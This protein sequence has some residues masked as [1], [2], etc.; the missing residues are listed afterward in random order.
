MKRFPAFPAVFAAACL[1]S[2]P[3]FALDGLAVF[4]SA[5]SS[6]QQLQKDYQESLLSSRQRRETK[7]PLQDALSQISEDYFRAAQNNGIDQAAL[8]KSVDSFLKNGGK[9]DSLTNPPV[10]FGS[11]DAGEALSGLAGG[12]QSGKSVDY[13]QAF[14]QIAKAELELQIDRSNLSANEKKL[15]K[16]AVAELAG[17]EGALLNASGNH[18]QAKLVKA[19]IPEESAKS[20]ADNV[21]SFISNTDNVAALKNA[22]YDLA[23]SVVSNY[24]GH[25]GAATINAAIEEYR[26]ADGTVKSAAKAALNASIDQYVRD[27]EAN[28]ALKKAIADIENDKTPDSQAVCTALAK[29]AAN[30]LIEE[31]NLSANEKKL[32]KAAVAELAGEEGALLNATGEHIMTKLVKAGVA[33]EQAKSISG[34]IQTFLADT[35]NTAA[36]KAAASESLQELVKQCVDEKGAAT[37]NSAIR[38]YMKADGT[39]GSAAETALNTAIDQ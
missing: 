29:S 22:S 12:I 16:A 24:V 18:I 19:G 8:G 13:K 34:N 35:G 28:A 5:T 36:I 39:V 1:L 30:K 17:E 15:A 26:S 27:P 11:T 25:K 31:S 9:I 32:A 23:E 10:L 38:E 2:A 21:C 14:T 33:E 6:P 20:I 7:N 4:S 3:L 37:I